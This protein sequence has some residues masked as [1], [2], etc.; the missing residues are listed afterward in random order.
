MSTDFKKE[1][2]MLTNQEIIDRLNLIG[3]LCAVLSANMTPLIQNKVLQ[4]QLLDT[5]LAIQS[6]LTKLSDDLSIYRSNG[7]DRILFA[8][9]TLTQSA[10]KS[11]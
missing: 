10:F 7:K 3:Q 5:L 8:V 9:F 6:D 4:S 11:V 1:I 2:F